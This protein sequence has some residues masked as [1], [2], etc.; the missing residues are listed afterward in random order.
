[1]WGYPPQL[2]L[3]KEAALQQL[4][5]KLI[6]ESLVE[7]VHDCAEGGLAVA[8]AEKSFANEIGA[9][10]KLASNGL[11]PEFVL[12]GE[13]A[14]RIL[15]SCDPAKVSRIQQVAKEKGIAAEVLGE[16]IPDR[17]EILLDGEMLVSARVS[18]LNVSYEN[19]LETSLR[20]DPQVVEAD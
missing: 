20:S 2:D 19:A 14:S 3:E 8:V 7:S 10:V 1:V 4:V 15:L 18:E 6:A 17:L 5:I 13:D 16:T 11:P 9:Q 12:F